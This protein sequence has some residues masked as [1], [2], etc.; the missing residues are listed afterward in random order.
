MSLTPTAVRHQKYDDGQPNKKLGEELPLPNNWALNAFVWALF[1]GGDD[2][3][4]L[5]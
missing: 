4:G 5:S 3:I 2:G 1:S